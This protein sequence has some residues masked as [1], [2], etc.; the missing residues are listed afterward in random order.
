MSAR[1]GDASASTLKHV[2]MRSTSSSVIALGEGEGLWVEG[3]GGLL[4]EGG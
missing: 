3:G 1:G 2:P 4:V